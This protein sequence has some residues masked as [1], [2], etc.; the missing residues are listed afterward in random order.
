MINLIIENKEL[1]KI[2]YA[3]VVGLI[4]AVIV[5][6]THRLFRLSHHQGIR[7]FRNAFLFYGIAFIVRYFLGA[8]FLYNSMS[9]DI[10]SLINF[11]FEYFL[12]MAGFFL[13]Y[14]LLWKKI[15]G[16]KRNYSSSLFNL[17]ILPFYVMAGIIVILDLLWNTREFMF[18]SQIILFAFA[19]IISYINYKKKGEK[20]R[21]LRFYVVA[22]ILSFLAWISNTIAA[23]YLKWHPLVLM[24]VY[25]SNILVFLLF[26]YG[27]IK[28]TKNG[29]EKGKVEHN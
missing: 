23:L 2:F 22:M 24:G 13:L 17:R 19:V 14:S 29:K 25:A 27:V 18:F 21:F 26:L 8:P 3:L 4:C 9:G 6:K 20:H 11:I 28:V 10:F 1:L 7:Y 15:E 12:I 16:T 5:L